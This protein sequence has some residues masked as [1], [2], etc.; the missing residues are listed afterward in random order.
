MEVGAG[1]VGVGANRAVGEGGRDEAGLAEA[2]GAGDGV[3]LPAG[4]YAC[5]VVVVF[6]VKPPE[7][8]APTPVE[9][10][11]VEDDLPGRIACFTTPPKLELDVEIVT[12]WVPALGS[13]CEWPVTP[14]AVLRF[15]GEP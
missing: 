3:A 7:T 10:L 2:E 1:E 5:H 14:I 13:T 8:E 12:V 6:A 11:E 9:P 15:A 4:E